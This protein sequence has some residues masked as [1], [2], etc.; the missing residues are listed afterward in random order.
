MD[1]AHP[2]ARD[3]RG[4]PLTLAAATAATAA[5]AAVALVAGLAAP[6]AAASQATFEGIVPTASTVVHGNLGTYPAGSMAVRIDGTPATAYCIDVGTSIEPGEAGLVE[7]EWASS[8]VPALDVVAGILAAYFP[9][10]DGPDGYRI[11]G[12]D[13]QQAAA[14]QAAIWHFTDGFELTRGSNDPVVEAG[15]AVVLAAA[16]AGALPPAGDPGVSLDVVPPASTSAEAGSLV[17]PFVV[18]TTAT[19]VTLS[20]SEGTTVADAAGRP[21][22]GPVGDGTHFWLAKPTAGDG[23]VRA[24]ARAVVHAGRVFA[25]E[26]SQR[27]ILASTVTTSVDAEAAASW[28]EPSTTSTTPPPTTT[29]RPPASTATPP[30]TTVRPPATAV[31]APPASTATTSPVAPAPRPL[32]PRDGVGPLRGSAPRPPVGPEVAT[33]AAGSL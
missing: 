26:G 29:V 4:A 28:S 15:Y 13:S 6:A 2:P 30:T 19:H 23:T 14:T 8:G 9:N 24:T 32:G 7:G 31:T 21:L 16:A 10:G 20:P 27:L 22:G 11:T 18:E 12:D 3:G 25:K 33:E 1:H 17:G 5:V